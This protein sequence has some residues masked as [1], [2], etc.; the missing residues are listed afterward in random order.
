MLFC[1]ENWWQ[2]TKHSLQQVKREKKWVEGFFFISEKKS[3]KNVAGGM[4]KY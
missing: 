3:V 1:T 4:E 2:A